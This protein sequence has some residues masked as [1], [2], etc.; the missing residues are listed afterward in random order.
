MK[1]KLVKHIATLSILF[2]SILLFLASCNS[3]ISNNINKLFTMAD[4]LIPDLI[5]ELPTSV[6]DITKE[7]PEGAMEAYWGGKD[8]G[9]MEWHSR[10]MLEDVRRFAETVASKMES[11]GID[12]PEPGSD[13]VTVIFDRIDFM[14]VSYNN[15]IAKFTPIDDY[16]LLEAFTEDNTQVLRYIAIPNKDGK[17]IKGY[18]AW[19]NATEYESAHS[20][21]PFVHE[22]EVIEVK[23]DIENPENKLLRVDTVQWHGGTNHYYGFIL[24]STYNEETHIGTGQYVDMNK[25]QDTSNLET[26]NYTI[27]YDLDTNIKCVGKYDEGTHTI[28]DTKQFGE[29]NNP[30]GESCSLTISDLGFSPLEYIN[31]DVPV[32]YTYDNV[33]CR[34]LEIINDWD[35]YINRDKVGF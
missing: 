18:F 1:K 32:P 17:I 16:I 31:G 11:N 20:T 35:G 5:K 13:P 7:I 30:T 14:N 9:D 8:N 22:K 29:D 24:K 6:S 34:I 28:I 3:M 2:F 27:K 33:N 15:F 26:Q 12:L 4:K 10:V 21:D 25:N 19:A 23:F